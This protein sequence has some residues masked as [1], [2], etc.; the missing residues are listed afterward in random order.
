MIQFLYH[1]LFQKAKKVFHNFYKSNFYQ[2]QNW[3]EHLIENGIKDFFRKRSVFFPSFLSHFAEKKM[4]KYL[5]S[6]VIGLALNLQI[7]LIGS[8]CTALSISNLKF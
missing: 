1:K 8:P 7:R 2:F 5:F 4:S 3:D 6:P